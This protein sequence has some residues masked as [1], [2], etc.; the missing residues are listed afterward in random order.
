MTVEGL[1]DQ[2]ALYENPDHTIALDV[3]VDGGTVWLTQQQMATLFGRDVTTV[4]RHIA[5]ARK[6]ELA[7]MATSAKFA[8]VQIEGDR[9]VERQVEHY[10]L[11]MVLSVGYRVKSPEGVYFRRW[12]NTVLAQHIT[13]GYTLNRKRLSD[14]GAM[15]QVLERADV[16]EIAGVASLVRAYLPALELL[17]QY[18]EGAIAEPA[19]V[20]ASW[21]MTYDDARAFVE[22]LPFYQTSGFFGRE[23]DGS[24]EGI[25]RGLYQS[26]AGVELYPSVQSKAAN[27]L[28]QVVKDHPFFDGN[29]RC[30]AALFVYFLQK[31]GLIDPAR[32]RIE[33]NTLAAMTLMVALSAPA[34]KDTMIALVQNLL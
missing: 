20:A 23:R 18:D 17:A 30:A 32:P 10:N 31:N 5:N 24:F 19:A 16:P 3:R 21:E 2:I 11:E 28:Y 26:F 34:E 7:G 13:K 33:P 9:T 4:R 14:L 6:E 25:I 22:S 8:L 1:Q 15:V 12:A 29:K 27:L